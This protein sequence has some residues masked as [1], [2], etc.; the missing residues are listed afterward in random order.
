MR[1]Q[2]LQNLCVFI[3]DAASAKLAVDWIEVCCILHNFSIQRR[4]VW[5]PE[6]EERIPEDFGH[7]EEEPLEEQG[8]AAYSRRNALLREFRRAQEVHQ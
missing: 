8:T 1:F 5:V 3:K 4:D 6:P 7:R 2:S